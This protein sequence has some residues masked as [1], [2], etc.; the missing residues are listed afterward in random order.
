MIKFITGT[1]LGAALAYLLDPVWGYD[2]RAGVTSFAKRLTGAAP[3]A[4]PAALAPSPAP[5]DAL[6]ARKVESLVHRDVGIPPGDVEIRADRGVIE[7]RGHVQAPQLA[8]ALKAT[9]GRVEGVIYIRNLLQVADGPLPAGRPIVAAAGTRTP[10]EVSG[11][12]ELGVEEPP[13]KDEEAATP[14]EMARASGGADL[15]PTELVG[16]TG[17]VEV[18]STPD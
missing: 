11:R 5:D 10:A 1:A 15:P 13:G 18:R 6:L 14:A 17:G 2:R 8:D 16:G 9:A 7:L 12:S 4:A 3:A